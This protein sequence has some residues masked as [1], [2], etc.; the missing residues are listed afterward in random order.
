ME[1]HEVLIIKDRLG[2]NQVIARDL[3]TQIANLAMG[4][5]HID[6]GWH[7]QYYLEKILGLLYSEDELAYIQDLE[8]SWEPG[9]AP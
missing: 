9:I 2:Y 8:E 1:S 5:L 3:H 6:E 7:K 4:G